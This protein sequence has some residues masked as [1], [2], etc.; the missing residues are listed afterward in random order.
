MRRNG[1]EKNSNLDNDMGAM[2]RMNCEEEKRKLTVLNAKTVDQLREQCQSTDSLSSP[3]TSVPP[4]LSKNELSSLHDNH[5]HEFRVL[6]GGL[7]HP[8]RD[9]YHVSKTY[10]YHYHQTN[11]HTTDNNT[12]STMN[13]KHNNV[14]NF[15]HHNSNTLPRMAETFSSVLEPSNVTIKTTNISSNTITRTEHLDS[16]LDNKNNDKY[17][18]GD[19]SG[20]IKRRRISLPHMSDTIAPPSSTSRIANVRLPPLVSTS[21]SLTRDAQ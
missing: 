4:S 9:S 13:N 12:S 2:K 7:K 17:D 14:N 1:R 8:N 5:D 21:P 6:P 3:P 15:N 10:S 18:Y 16:Y 11:D 20:D 19:P